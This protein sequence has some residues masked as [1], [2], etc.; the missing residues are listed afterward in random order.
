MT[1]NGNIG[2]QEMDISDPCLVSSTRILRWGGRRHAVGNDS[3]GLLGQWVES[4]RV[5]IR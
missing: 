2:V 4:V 5:E 3:R 1:V